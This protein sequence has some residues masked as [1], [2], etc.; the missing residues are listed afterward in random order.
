MILN[1]HLRVDLAVMIKDGTIQDVLQT[2]LK[3]AD[4]IRIQQH[5]VILL[6]D[7]VAVS[8]EDDMV[9]RQGAGLVRA[10]H[11][12]RAKVLDGIQLFDNHLLPRHENCAAGE[13]HRNDHGQHFGCESYGDGEREEKRLPPVAFRQPV[14]Q[15]HERNHDHHKTEH[16]PGE[17]FDP[18]VK[19]RLHLLARDARRHAS[20]IRLLA[21]RNNQCQRRTAFD[22]RTKIAD[23]GELKGRHVVPSLL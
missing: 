8:L 11:I 22:A 20:E 7:D 21:R 19:A 3:V 5:Q 10:E 15:K 6:L 16:E 18:F 2:S 1:T 23:V 13:T 4:Q 12:H 9:H 14:D 17:A